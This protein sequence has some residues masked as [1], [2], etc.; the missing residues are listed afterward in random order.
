MEK[1]PLLF[2]CQPEEALGAKSFNPEDL[3]KTYQHAITL[4][5]KIEERHGAP[6]APEFPMPVLAMAIGIMLLKTQKEYPQD[7]MEQLLEQAKA[8]ILAGAS[9]YGFSG[10]LD[11]AAARA[12]QAE[13]LRVWKALEAKGWNYVHLWDGSHKKG[14]DQ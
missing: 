5:E 12:L 6:G 10:G 2:E 13:T 8:L 4:V 7:T 3:E 11:K 1:K 9:G 14:E